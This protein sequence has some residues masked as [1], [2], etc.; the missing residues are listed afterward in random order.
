MR[1]ILF[2]LKLWKNKKKSSLRE[3]TVVAKQKISFFK[4]IKIGGKIAGMWRNSL[5]A[6][7]G[8]VNG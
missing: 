5:F 6:K 7:L 1:K 4:K 3:F 2:F 8:V